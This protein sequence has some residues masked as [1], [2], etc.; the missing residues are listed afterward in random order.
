M[1]T[2]V[3]LNVV[4]MSEKASQDDSKSPVNIPSPDEDHR[5][6]EIDENPHF[7]EK[8]DIQASISDIDDEKRQQPKETP[9]GSV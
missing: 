1:F 7:I 9:I 4:R 3:E 5:Q 8:D 2:N 6:S